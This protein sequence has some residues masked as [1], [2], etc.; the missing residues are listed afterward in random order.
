VS[1]AEPAPLSAR[2]KKLLAFREGQ[3]TAG[4][5][6]P[7]GQ[8]GKAREGFLRWT[9][10]SGALLELI[11]EVSDWPG[12]LRG[13]TV[14]IHGELRDL[15]EITLLWAWPKTWTAEQRAYRFSSAGLA[16]G[17]HT[18]SERRWPMV[19]YSTA[20]LSEWRRDTGLSFSHSGSPSGKDRLDVVEVR[21]AA[22]DVVQ[23]PTALLRFGGTANWSVSYAPVWSV[24]TRQDMVVQPNRPRTIGQF[25][26]DFGEPLAALTAF[27]AASRDGFIREVLRDPGSG[28]RV[29]I[30][31]TDQPEQ[32]REWLTKTRLLFHADELPDFERAIR[33]WW[34]TMQ[35]TWPAISVFSAQYHDENVYSPARLITVHAALEAYARGR[36]RHTDFKRLRSYARVESSVTGCSNVA[37]D[38]LGAC[39]GYFAHLNPPT[40]KYTVDQIEAAI[41]PSIRRASALM[42]ACLLRELGFSKAEATELLQAHYGT[43]PLN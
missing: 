21:P 24:L 11:S 15:G 2:E 7:A 30:W 13:G 17:S 32:P 3:T 8:P 9:S 37:L 43:W 36:H 22:T 34:K 38:L 4:V 25:R 26:R 5:F 39:R 27:M 28:E 12:D 40:K 20:Y 10:E 16:L 19:I 31:H 6:W 35:L 42:Q 18:D 29:E 33:R 1:P 23:L 14:A 41:L